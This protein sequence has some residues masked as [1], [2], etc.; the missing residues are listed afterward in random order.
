MKDSAKEIFEGLRDICRNSIGE[1]DDDKSCAAY[2]EVYK[3]LEETG[4]LDYDCLRHLN[5]RGYELAGKPE[6]LTFSECCTVL[7]FLLRAERF[8]DGYFDGHYF[9]GAFTSALKDGTV[10]RIL[11]RACE[12]LDAE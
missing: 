11:D 7:T 3:G 2:S 9:G 8:T 4:N 10:Y 5:G 6:K 1:D 12:L